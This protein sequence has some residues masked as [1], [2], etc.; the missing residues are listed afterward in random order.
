MQ[1]FINQPAQNGAP[2]PQ[3]EQPT[4]DQATPE[5]QKALEGALQ[6]AS[7]LLYKEDSTH[8]Q[9]MKL[10][11]NYKEE[12]QA[13]I[14]EVT[15]QVVTAVDQQ[16][17]LPETVIMEFTAVV[18]DMVMELG[19]ATGLAKLDER[20]QEDTLALTTMAILEEYGAEPGDLE[21]VL[22]SMTPEEQEQLV[23]IAERLGS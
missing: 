1:G 8:Q 12:P 9:Y 18:T 4:G 17:D 7:H 13:G 11:E 21:Q 16:L 2:Q 20:Q 19:E 22:A 10:M 23:P 14:I 15:K 6:A 5:E 3:A